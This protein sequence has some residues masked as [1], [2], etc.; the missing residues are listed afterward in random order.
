MLG[1]MGE[2]EGSIPVIDLASLVGGVRGTIRKTELS[3]D[4]TFWSLDLVGISETLLPPLQN[5][6]RLN[7]D[8]VPADKTY[9][10]D[11]GSL[12]QT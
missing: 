11:R 10:Q 12:L 9:G 1:G 3:A 5:A 2:G 6:P 8:S 4:T 7:K